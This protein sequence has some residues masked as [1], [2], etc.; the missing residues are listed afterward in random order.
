MAVIVN[1]I[2]AIPV[3]LMYRIRRREDEMPVLAVAA[4]H[5]RTS[6][7]DETKDVLEYVAL[8]RDIR[9]DNP[10]PVH[11]ETLAGLSLERLIRGHGIRRVD[12]L[13]L[14]WERALRSVSAL[15]S[16]DPYKLY[17]RDLDRYPRIENSQIEREIA[18][19]ARAGDRDAVERLVTGNLPFV[20]S[21]VKQYRGRG[22]SLAELVCIGNEGLVTA[23]GKYDP[24]RG[25]KSF[26]MQN[27]GSIKR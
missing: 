27:G 18:R 16:F 21:Y 23:E 24:D 9:I 4:V 25:V 15:S 10:D 6:R 19:R 1:R 12:E 11:V 22:L 26:L 7:I 3:I 2:F 5:R 14:A 13:H 20:I 8:V 17:L